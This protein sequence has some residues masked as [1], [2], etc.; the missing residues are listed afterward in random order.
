MREISY[1]TSKSRAAY[2]FIAPG[3]VIIICLILY[4]IIQTAIM[5]FT[6]W[7]LV[8][9]KKGHPFVGFDNYKDFFGLTQFPQMVKVTLI[10]IVAGV[11]GK[12][13]A[14]L[15]TA[16]LLNRKFWGRA[17]VRAI[18]IIPWAMP[19]VVVCV[20]F[21]VALDP[22]YGM[23]N[24][25]LLDLRVISKP[26]PFFLKP[27]LALVAVIFVEIWRYFPFIAVMLLAALQGIPQELYDAASLDGAGVFRKF[28]RITWPWITPVW[29][30]VL[31]LQLVWTVQEFELVYLITRGGPNFGTQI[32]GVDVYLN[33][34][35]FFKMGTASAEGMFL[36]L[37]SLIFAV[38]YFGFIQKRQETV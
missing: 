28:A 15:G 25:I 6:Y 13:G 38:V 26:I 20:L 35:R 18:M 23:V 37:F 10:Y 12:M 36:V 17:V 16:L 11:L 4:P 9:P 2:L 14:G 5:S 33:A 34:F 24:A 32:I 29:Y 27:D 19:T 22:T 7:Y 21:M 30:I 31:I 1:N 8:M 3:T